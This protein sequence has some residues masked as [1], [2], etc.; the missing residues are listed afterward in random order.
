MLLSL[1]RQRRQWQRWSFS[2]FS[3]KHFGPQ[4][5]VEQDFVPPGK[6]KV[7]CRTNVL[8]RNWNFWRQRAR[9]PAAFQRRGENR[10]FWCSAIDGVVDLPCK[11]G[12]TAI[13]PGSNAVKAT[14]AREATPHGTRVSTALPESTTMTSARQS[15]RSPICA[16]QITVATP[17][18]TEMSAHLPFTQ[19]HGAAG[20]SQAQSQAQSQARSRLRSTWFVLGA[21]TERSL[22]LCGKPVCAVAQS[23]AQQWPPA[24]RRRT[25][26]T[27]VPASVRSQHCK[28]SSSLNKHFPR[29]HHD[30]QHQSPR[31]LDHCCQRR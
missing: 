6:T 2:F 12:S 26:P 27:A 28:E 19:A 16:S 31:R 29:A 17:A 9:R 10:C 7:L 25:L 23:L 21:S 13:G 4:S 14:N 5:T 1:S 11:Q 22:L 8:R 20:P 15:A 24:S 3:F 30:E 18:C